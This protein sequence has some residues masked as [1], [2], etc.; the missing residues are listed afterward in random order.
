VRVFR[1][2][3]E[4]PGGGFTF[5]PPKSAAGLRTVV[6][7]DLIVP[8]LSWPLARFAGP[9]RTACCS[10]ARAG[11]RCGTPTS[12]AGSGSQRSPR[13]TCPRSTFMISVTLATCW[14][15]ARARISAS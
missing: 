3:A 8:D 5:G 7:P 4:S 11:V 12:A 15:L 1:Q 2:L 6:F 10:L 14:R 9:A 13:L